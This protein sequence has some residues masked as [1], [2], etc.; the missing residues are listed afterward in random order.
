V[1]GVASSV[2]A[3]FIFARDV[4]EVKFIVRKTARRSDERAVIEKPINGINKVR[5]GVG[6]MLIGRVKA[7]GNER[8]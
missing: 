8:I 3:Y 5:R 7:T 1:R 2:L 4:I 6:T